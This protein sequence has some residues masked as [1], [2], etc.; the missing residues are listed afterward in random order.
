[1]LLQI[2]KLHDP[3]VISGRVSLTIEYVV[4]Y[5]GWDSLSRRKLVVLKERLDALGKQIRPARHKLI[6]H[7]DLAAVLGDSALGAFDAGADRKYFRTL[8]SFLTTVYW[9]ATGGPCAAF[10][11]FSQ[12]DANQ[13]IAALARS[14]RP[15]R[16]LATIV[17]QP[18]VR[19]VRRTG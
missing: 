2:A 9:I 11:T 16:P 13:V 17:K 4:E 14:T 1:M 5:G 6:A 8:Q 3:A 18:T 7:N 15:R 19:A 12:G 10:S